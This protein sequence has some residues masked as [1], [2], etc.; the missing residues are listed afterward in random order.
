MNLSRMVTL[1]SCSPLLQRINER[2]SINACLKHKSIPEGY[3]E[4]E[5]RGKG[6]A[7]FLLEEKMPIRKGDR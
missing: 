7:S 1:A 2:V 5:H 3:P 6:D 4:I